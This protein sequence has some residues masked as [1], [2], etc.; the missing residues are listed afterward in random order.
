MSLDV[1]LTLKGINAG[2]SGSGIFVRE[3]GQVKEISRQ[4][5]DEKFPGRDPVIAIQDGDDDAV[6]TA[7]ITHNLNTMASEVGIYQ[8]LWRPDELDITLAAQ[9]I[10]PL[11]AGLDLL[12]SDPVRFKE[13]NPSN[14]WGEYEDLVSFVRG[15]LRAC[16]MYPTAGVSVSR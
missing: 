16:I 13:F 1:Y 3:S 6:Y 12:E 11:R 2:H 4:E 5:W 8:Y 9:L 14:G 15:Y 10:G 7:N